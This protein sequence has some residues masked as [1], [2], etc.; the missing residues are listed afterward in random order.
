M[1]V[2]VRWV[3][4]GT[5]SWFITT[6]PVR[7]EQRDTQGHW[8]LLSQ[9]GRRAGLISR[10]LLRPCGTQA[11]RTR[12]HPDTAPKTSMETLYNQPALG[13]LTGKP[14]TGTKRHTWNLGAEYLH[15]LVQFY[16]G[17]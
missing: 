14:Q 12:T 17:Q 4:L 1:S 10:L 16:L 7:T 8:V 2:S 5:V 3:A 11:G 15:L 13:P 6:S 9:S